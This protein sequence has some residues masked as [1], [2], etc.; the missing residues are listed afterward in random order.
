MA[1]PFFPADWVS[2]T[3]EELATA[4]AKLAG[5]IEALPDKEKI[6]REVKIF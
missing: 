2:L 3:P 1:K 4:R 5:F 6:L